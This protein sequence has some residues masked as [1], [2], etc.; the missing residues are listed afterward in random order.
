MAA[1]G[2]NMTARD[3]RAGGTVEVA[4]MELGVLEGLVKH[5][6][7]AHVWWYV[8]YKSNQC[9]SRSCGVKGDF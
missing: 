8:S 3:V 2:S 7:T 6:I 4:V 5:D 1:C 9:Q